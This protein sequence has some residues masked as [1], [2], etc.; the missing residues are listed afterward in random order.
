M[1]WNTMV[2]IATI[3]SALATFLYAILVAFTLWYIHRQL[4]EFKKNRVLQVLLAIFGELRTSESRRAR[5]YIYEQTPVDVKSLSNDKLK[6]HMRKIEV[7]I[8]A[9]NRIGYLAKERYINPKLMLPA[10]WPMIWRCWKKCENLTV[11]TRIRRNEPDYLKN[12]QYLFEL[13]EQYRINNNLP[14]PIFF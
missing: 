3:I 5:Q 8:T 10:Y 11:F 4:E 6:K 9:F 2:S 7:V 13:A 14:E 1:N 12:F